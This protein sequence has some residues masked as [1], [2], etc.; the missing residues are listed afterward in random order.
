MSEEEIISPR[1]EVFINEAG[2]TD[3]LNDCSSSSRI[4]CWNLI[5]LSH[6][7]LLT[8]EFIIFLYFSRGKFE[9]SIKLNLGRIN[10]RIEIFFFEM[11]FFFYK[12]NCTKSD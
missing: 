1:S 12:K 6:L 4:S 11:F 3:R 8:F 9:K 10:F 2:H 7:I 5:Y